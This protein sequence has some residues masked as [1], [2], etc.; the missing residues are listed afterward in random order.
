MRNWRYSLNKF[1]SLNLPLSSWTWVRR[2]LNFGYPSYIIHKSKVFSIY[3]APYIFYAILFCLRI[4]N[5]GKQVTFGGSINHTNNGYTQIKPSKFLCW[6]GINSHR[7]WH[8]A[9]II[10]ISAINRQGF[11]KNTS[12]QIIFQ[13]SVMLC[14]L[15]DQSPCWQNWKFYSTIYNTRNIHH[16]DNLHTNSL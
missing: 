10:S 7:T 15:F 3:S 12:T 13:T 2:S 8:W 14:T 16:L 1:A 11:D 9:R 4:A 6:L 5:I